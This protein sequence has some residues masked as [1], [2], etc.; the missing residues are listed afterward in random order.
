MRH[1]YYDAKFGPDGYSKA[2]GA[3]D[4]DIVKDYALT[5]IGLEPVIPMMAQK[6][7]KEM[8]VYAENWDGFIK[9]A[10]SEYVHTTSIYGSLT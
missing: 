9:M 4:E 7:K 2:L 1:L 10:G 5:T 6:F 8:T 3:S